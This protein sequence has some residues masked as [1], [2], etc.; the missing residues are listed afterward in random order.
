MAIPGALR[1][2]TKRT[3]ER[4][5]NYCRRRYSGGPLAFRFI[6]LLVL[7]LFF[8]QSSAYA[9]RDAQL[10]RLTDGVRVIVQPEP[11]SSAMVLNVFVRE[12]PTTTAGEE[13]ARRMVN[14]AL[15]FG[16]THRSYEDTVNAVNRVGSVQ[17]TQTPDFLCI[18]CITTA[19]KYRDAIFLVSEALK[20]ALFDAEALERARVALIR[21]ADERTSDAFITAFD[22]LSRK[23]MAHIEPDAV[24]LRHVTS[25][26]AISYHKRYFLPVRTVISVAGNFDIGLILRSLDNNLIDYGPPLSESAPLPGGANRQTGVK[27][28]TPA[29][30]AQP[31]EQVNAKSHVSF[32]LL[33]AE[34]PPVSDPDYPAVH[35]LN[36]LL[37]GGHASR[38]YQRIR[39][40]AGIGYNVG[41]TLQEDQSDPL[42]AYVEW[43]ASHQ[44]SGVEV[45]KLLRAQFDSLIS[46]HAQITDAEMERARNFSIGQYAL[47]HERL[48]ER[49]YLPGW[50]EVMGAGYRFDHDLP[51]RLAAVSRE[52]LLR[53]AS[54]YLSRNASILAIAAP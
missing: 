17:T 53:V 8:P 19:A 5:V 7:S 28:Q 12:P 21:Q 10:S 39:E 41:A 30:E 23:V 40:A 46:A 42:T 45:M 20:N 51:D 48:L 6:C 18:T 34:T 36:N 31:T 43:H 22:R 27:P 37:G 4:R 26:L 3:R 38:I 15:F 54:R 49:A 2:G 33:A 44:I 13:A 1:D 50:Y 11:E 25:E 32:A 24:Q 35:V 9:L 52:D 29:P 16:S 14:S 47:K